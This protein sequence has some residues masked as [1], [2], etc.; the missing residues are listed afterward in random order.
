MSEE[1]YKKVVVSTRHSVE[2]INQ[3]TGYEWDRSVP[4]PKLIV[5][6]K[7]KTGDLETVEIVPGLNGVVVIKNERDE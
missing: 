4:Y 3:V 1:R 7:N 5:E 6:F 2:I